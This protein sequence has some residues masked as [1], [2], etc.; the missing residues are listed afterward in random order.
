M[1]KTV[2]KRTSRTFTVYFLFMGF[3]CVFSRSPFWMKFKFIKP[4]MV[5]YT[6]A[7]RKCLLYEN[8]HFMHIKLLLRR[9]PLRGSSVCV[10]FYNWSNFLDFMCCFYFDVRKK[11]QFKYKLVQAVT[12][13]KNQHLNEIWSSLTTFAGTENETCELKVHYKFAVN[14][15]CRHKKKVSQSFTFAFF[16]FIVFSP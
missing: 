15:K 10:K 8:K 14:F 5:I 11:S 2:T 4:L 12:W 9:S 16:Y 3:F 1:K 6:F 7:V 13:Q